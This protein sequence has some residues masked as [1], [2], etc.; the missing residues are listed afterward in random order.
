MTGFLIL[1]YKTIR[2]TTACV[3]SI[4]GLEDAGGYH[5]LIADNGS[6]DGTYEE[7]AARYAD[8]GDV[9]VMT[10]G[11][12]L[13]FSAGN[14]AGWAAFP[15]RE[16]LDALVV[17]NSDVV[18]AQKDFLVRL[19][20][21]PDYDILGPDI[22]V[23]RGR[24][25]VHSSPMPPVAAK[26]S[27][28]R[29]NRAVRQARL[30]AAQRRPAASLLSAKLHYPDGRAMA[31][32][33]YYMLS[34]HWFRFKN[35]MRNAP[36]VGVLLQGACLIF[37]RRYCRRYEKLFDPEPFLYYEELLLWLKARRDNLLV[38][39]DPSLWVQ[40]WEG[41]ATKA[42]A[43]GQIE[44]YLFVQRQ[45]ERSEQLVLERF[46]CLAASDPEKGPIA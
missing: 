25:W 24:R 32:H 41:R 15:G 13:G 10:T 7:L 12:N 36:D 8:D 42:D 28:V 26:E 45:M 40:H 31:G 19:A 6:A 20:A 14:N 27:T 33:L 5:I 29:C 22:R 16:A 38:R 23:P 34:S 35:Q 39:Y 4:R 17:C 44:H 46:R 43:A 11:Q 3:D 37:S 18:F 9:T 21:Q 2:E 30:A 1:H